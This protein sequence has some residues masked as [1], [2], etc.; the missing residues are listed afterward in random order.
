MDKREFLD[1]LQRA[2]ASGVSSS[3]VAENVRYYQDYIES[4][5]RKGRNEQEVLEQLGDPRLLAKSII[6]A[7]KRSGASY[8]SN[9]EYDE[10]VSQETSGGSGDNFDERFKQRDIKIPGWLI[11]VIATVIIILFIGIATSLISVLS[12]VIIVVLVIL[13]IVKLFQNNTK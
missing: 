2:L 1:K 9:R 12:P 4:E 11:M 10:E 8:G 5:I 6:E 7:N 13:L 3:Q